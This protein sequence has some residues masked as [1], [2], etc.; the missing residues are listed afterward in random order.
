MTGERF[1]KTHSQ[2]ASLTCPTVPGALIV[3]NVENA[4]TTCMP[5]LT[6]PAWFAFENAR[7]ALSPQ[8][9]ATLENTAGKHL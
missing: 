2:N 3:F 9:L 5:F 7:K 6:N 4:G 1:A 8:T